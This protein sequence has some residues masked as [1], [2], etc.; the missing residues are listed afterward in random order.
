MLLCFVQCFHHDPYRGPRYSY[1]AVHDNDGRL[2]GD[3]AKRVYPAVV[4]QTVLPT[5]S[6]GLPFY[7]ALLLRRDTSIYIDS[8]LEG[9]CDLVH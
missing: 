5:E 6:L 7:I 1:A 4:L 3:R 9:L 2:S 8:I